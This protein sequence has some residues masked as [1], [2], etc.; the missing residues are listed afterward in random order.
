MKFTAR[1]RTKMLCG[2]QIPG[3]N[4]KFGIWLF[5]GAM[6]VMVAVVDIRGYW[7][8]GSLP[9]KRRGRPHGTHIR[10]EFARQ[11]GSF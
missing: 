8:L 6:G 9:D 7:S 4:E 1:N 10:D 3:L 11:M 2:V 5:D